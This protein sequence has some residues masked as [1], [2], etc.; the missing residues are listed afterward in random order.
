MMD[1]LQA[2]QVVDDTKL[3]GAVDLLEGRAADHT[4][5]GTLEERGDRNC[6]N[7]TMDKHDILHWDANP[8]PAEWAGP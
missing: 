8:L 3:G 7:F 4:D 6:R 2:H 1:V 5:Q